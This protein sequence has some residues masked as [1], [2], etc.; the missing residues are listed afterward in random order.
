MNNDI[1]V[2]EFNT[3]YQDQVIELILN[4]QQEEYQIA[5]SIEDQ[6]DLLSIEKFYR[7]GA[8]NFW[9]AF[10]NGQVV[11]TIALLDIGDGK[12]ALRKMF[13][14]QEFR[15]PL[16]QTGYLLLSAAKDWAKNN[17]ISEIYLGT[18]SQFLAAHRFFE[19]NGFISLATE[20]LPENFPIM[21]VDSKFYKY[22]VS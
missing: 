12:C 14:R 16:I 9:V 2:R 20:E 17:K 8:G 15:G 18:T 22:V 7:N 3:E 5:I 1:I 6:P 11:G 19:K 10:Y 21:K 4:I 13:V